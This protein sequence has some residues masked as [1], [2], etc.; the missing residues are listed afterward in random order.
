MIDWEEFG[1]KLVA[2]NARLA[3]VRLGSGSLVMHTKMT[4]NISKETYKYEMRPI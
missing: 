3:A 1:A 4:Y 2:E